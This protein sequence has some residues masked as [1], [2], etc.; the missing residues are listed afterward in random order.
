MD[1]AG[2][3]LVWFIAMFVQMLCWQVLSFLYMFPI[4]LISWILKRKRDWVACYSLA[5]AIQ[6]PGALLLGLALLGYESDLYKLEGLLIAGAIHFIVALFFLITTPLFLPP[7]AKPKPIFSSKPLQT[8]QNE[9][10]ITLQDRK[11]NPFS[12]RSAKAADSFNGNKKNPF[13]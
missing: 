10:D 9:T 7:G 5:G 3:F 1:G 8:S 2:H 11:K 6:M 4:E 13:K 12:S